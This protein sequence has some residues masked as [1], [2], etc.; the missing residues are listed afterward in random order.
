MFELGKAYRRLEVMDLLGVPDEISRTG[1]AWFTGYARHE[2]AICVFCNVGN[3]GRTGHNYS[4]RWVGQSLQ[5][6][7]NGQSRADQPF[8]NDMINGSHQ[9]H[10]F[11]RAKDRDP[12]IYAGVGHPQEVSGKEPVGITWSFPG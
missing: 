10:V 6:Y 4:N 12:F 5:W 11:W 1:G 7:G 8:I 2:S 9:V 3:A